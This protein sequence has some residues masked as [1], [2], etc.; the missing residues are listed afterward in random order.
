MPQV[1]LGECGAL[2]FPAHAGMDPAAE[3]VQQVVHHN[4]FPAHAGM[5]PRRLSE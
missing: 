5:D 3:G 4:G 2:G 1:H